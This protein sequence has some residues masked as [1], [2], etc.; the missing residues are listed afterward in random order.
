MSTKKKYEGFRCNGQYFFCSFPLSLDTYNGCTHFCRY[1]FSYFNYL[2]NQ[3]TK[4][5]NFYTDYLSTNFNVI[6]RAFRD[7]PTDKDTKTLKTYRKLIKERMPIH[8]GGIS[9]PFSGFELI[10]KEHVSLKLLKLFNEFQYPI[11]M[12]TKSK[13]IVDNPEY[14]KEIQ[15]NKNFIFQVSLITTNEKLDKVEPGTSVA[16]RL[17]LIEK[18]SKTNRVVVR[19]QPFIPNFCEEDIEEYIKTIAKKG[20]SALTIEFLKLSAFTSPTVKKAIKDLGVILGYD[21]ARYYKYKGVMTATDVEIRTELKRPTIQKFKD[22][23]HKYGMEFYCADNAL[24]DMGDG[25][26]CCGIPENYPGFE[27]YFKANISTGLFKAKKDGVMKFED[28]YGKLR[29]HEKEFLSQPVSKW[30]NLGTAEH[31]VMHSEHTF[32]DKAG[33]QWDNPGHQNSPAKFFDSIEVAGKDKKGHLIYKYKRH[34]APSKGVRGSTRDKT[35][36]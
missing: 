1:C 31:H 23:A 15:E 35:D 25:P 26:I 29:P 2:I 4:G 13:W 18:V 21:V 19:C 10:D 5:K 20:A 14:L 33:F 27:N 8:W 11:I 16:K 3:A 12:S 24:R 28:V 32:L 17:E 7:K 6:E 30:L 9:D 22:L 36:R 34:E